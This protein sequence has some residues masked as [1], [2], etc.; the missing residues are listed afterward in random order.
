MGILIMTIFKKHL[1]ETSTSEREFI[2]ESDRCKIIFEYMR[3]IGFKFLGAGAY[4][5][6]FINSKTN[7]V[8]IVLYDKSAREES[9]FSS[10][11]K[12]CLKHS[13]NPHLPQIKSARPLLIH[14][15]KFIVAH[16]ER[17]FEIYDSEISEI[18]GALNDI[19]VACKHANSAVSFL[20]QDARPYI[21]AD[22]KSRLEASGD[23]KEGMSLLVLSVE[24]YDL[25]LTT[26]LDLIDAMPKSTFLDLHSGNIMLAS[27]GTIVFTDPWAPL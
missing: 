12:F 18:S 19:I 24:D 17:L 1:T 6:A 4:K 27:D 13:T 10:W 20:Q 3:G 21:L 2:L 23:I 25:L 22:A 26:I 15:E 9:N 8:K 14:G 11:I 5:A 16:V 7:N